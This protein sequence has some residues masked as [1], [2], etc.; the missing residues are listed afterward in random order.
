M[1]V[2]V[3]GAAGFIGRALVEA[4]V[5]DERVEEVVAI[6]LDPVVRARPKLRAVRRDI[7]DPRVAVEVA[8]ADALVELAFRDHDVGATV[9]ASVAGARN[10]FEAA[11]EAGAGTIVYASSSAAY[12]S[13]PDNPV[14]LSEDRPLR[15]APFAYPMT[16][17]AVEGMLEDL[18]A[19][20]PGTRIVRLRPSWVIGPG[21]RMLL[22][23]RVYVSLSDHDP[24]VQ[25]TWIDDAIAAF[26]A[27]L[28]TGTA[29]G[30]FNV[31]AP[32]TVRSS[33]IAGLLG[34]RGVRLPH[35]ARRA[36]AAT[37][38]RLRLPGA[39]HP[40]FVDMDRYPIVLDATRA[41]RE[42]GW[43]PRHDTRGALE[44]LR[45]AL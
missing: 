37:A 31:G 14:P 40:G 44:R 24:E 10:L 19:A 2:A 22:G 33:E 5:R 20:W 3:T 34:V 28:H 9:E 8:G 39:L 30:P 11:I 1:R 32:G 41:E 42:L 25:F 6:D 29:R 23:G 27:A 38:T 17:A 15:P 4:L 16:K 36:A 45:A 35:R 26:T 7:R 12:G 18:A 13:A 43:R 21:A